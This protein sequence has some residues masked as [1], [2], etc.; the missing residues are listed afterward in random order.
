[1]RFQMPLWCDDEW[2]FVADEAMKQG[3]RVR[4]VDVEGQLLRVK[5]EG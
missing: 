5:K 2:P 4:V 3:D 1:M